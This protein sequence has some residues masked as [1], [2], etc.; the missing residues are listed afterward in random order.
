MQ[1]QLERAGTEFKYFRQKLQD[2]QL[3][4]SRCEEFES[5][6]QRSQNRIELGIKQHSAEIKAYSST[7]HLLDQ[8][9]AAEEGAMDLYKESSSE[10]TAM[11][12]A[13]KRIQ[14]RY[15]KTIS[16]YAAL[17]EVKAPDVTMVDLAEK[18]QLNGEIEANAKLQEANAKL[19]EA[20]K[21]VE[22]QLAQEKQ[23]NVSSASRKV[24]DK[25]EVW[26]YEQ[27]V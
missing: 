16:E 25:A 5:E 8:A 9:V 21:D 3:L 13:E 7:K 26:K 27:K 12:F 15:D 17:K 23:L 14:G 11:Q 18:D 19:Q 6:Y 10:L 4:E 20:M 24:Q 1:L 2:A 22:E